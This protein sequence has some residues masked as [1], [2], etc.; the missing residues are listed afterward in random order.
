MLDPKDLEDI[1]N[2]TAYDV[3]VDVLRAILEELKAANELLAS[4][5][6]NLIKQE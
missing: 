2:S 1:D 3:Q 6:E 5:N 4:I